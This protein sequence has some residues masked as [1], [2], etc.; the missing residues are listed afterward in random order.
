VGR[1]DREIKIDNIGSRKPNKKDAKI[2]P[3][4]KSKK[5]EEKKVP[6]ALYSE[7]VLALNNLISDRYEPR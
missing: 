3:D 4:L 6:N 2:A 7:S 5:I 1:S